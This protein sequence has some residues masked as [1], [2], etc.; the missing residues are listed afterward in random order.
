MARKR[1]GIGIRT[2]GELDVDV[3]LVVWR[4]GKATVKD[5]FEV[6]YETRR[7]AYTTIMTVMSRLAKKGI[8]RQ[9]RSRT[10]YE[11]T[12]VVRR[13]ELA[14]SIVN[15]VV[16]RLLDG[17]ADALIKNLSHKQEALKPD[18]AAEMVEYKS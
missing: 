9:D 1:P 10:P 16:D 8:L 5:V 18:A 15:H 6:L 14:F 13:D 11:Y 12:P 17:S 4:L 2:L 3:L 7:L